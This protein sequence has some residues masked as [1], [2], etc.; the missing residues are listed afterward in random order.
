MRPYEPN[1]N[2]TAA[3]VLAAGASTRLG[4][5]KQL[6]MLGAETLLER[7]IRVAK[8]AACSPIV[9][10]LGSSAEF[11]RKECDFD[12]VQLVFNHEWRQGMA[13]SIRAGLKTL[14]DVDGVVLMVCDMPAVSSAH[15]RALAA[16]GEI[17]ASSYAGRCGV[18]A[19][20]PQ[21]IFPEL[22]RLQGDIGARDLLRTAPSIELPGGELDVDTEGDLNIAQQRFG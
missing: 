4:Q 5:P 22:L 11:I 7:S 20:L 10:V 14:H 18:P 16:S 21:S 19:Y 8:E 9:V 6:V 13:T 1:M 17:A 2:K 12:G 15:L 3:I